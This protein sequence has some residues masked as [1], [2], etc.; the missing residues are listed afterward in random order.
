[1]KTPLN[2]CRFQKILQWY[3]R[4]IDTNQKL[5][6]RWLSFLKHRSKKCSWQ[7]H[8]WGDCA[9]AKFRP[10][11]ENFHMS[12]AVA[13]KNPRYYRAAR[14]RNQFHLSSRNVNHAY[15]ITFPITLFLKHANNVR[16]SIF[17]RISDTSVMPRSVYFPNSIVR[18]FNPG[19]FD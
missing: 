18:H 6:S 9:L 2:R 17:R 11:L 12:T 1:M 3:G 5:S 7:S 8:R 13:R 19:V 10:K 16:A 14:I 4:N 15:R